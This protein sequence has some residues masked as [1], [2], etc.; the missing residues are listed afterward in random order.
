MTSLLAT[1][2]SCM[3]THTY[4]QL[5]WR[6]VGGRRLGGRQR[7]SFVKAPLL[8]IWWKLVRWRRLNEQICCDRVWRSLPITWLR[9]SIYILLTKKKTITTQRADPSDLLLGKATLKLLGSR[10]QVTYYLGVLQLVHLPFARSSWLSSHFRQLV[11]TNSIVQLC[12]AFLEGVLS[13][14]SASAAANTRRIT[15]AFN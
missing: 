11:Q 12:G 14:G 10:S 1:C 7:D 13:A 9:V 8:L 2:S 15:R 3:C 6:R 4:H 5:P